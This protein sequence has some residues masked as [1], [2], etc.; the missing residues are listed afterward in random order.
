MLLELRKSIKS[1]IDK[2]DKIIYSLERA[3]YSDNYEYSDKIEPIYNFEILMAYEIDRNPVVLITYIDDIPI[4]YKDIRDNLRVF[5]NDKEVIYFIKNKKNEY[6]K[7]DVM[8]LYIDYPLF[9]GKDDIKTI[10]LK[11]KGKEVSKY[12]CRVSDL[13]Q[14]EC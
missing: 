11:Y 8:Q 2:F 1:L 10:T 12:A 4:S 3:I 6:S 7:N 13:Y 9:D 14:K 5:I